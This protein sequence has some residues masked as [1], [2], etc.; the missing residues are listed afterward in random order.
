MFSTMPFGSETLCD[1]SQLWFKGIP[2]EVTF[3]LSS[4]LLSHFTL[5]GGSSASILLSV[6][7]LTV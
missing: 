1:D 6:G 3:S 2:K 7:L 4:T 5:D